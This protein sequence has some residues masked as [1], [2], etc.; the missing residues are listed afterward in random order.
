MPD[1]PQAPQKPS[2][3]KKV[4]TLEAIGFVWDVLIAIAI[5]TVLFALGGRW[6][7]QHWHT[8]PLFAVIGLF[9][10]LA[11]TLVLMM[12]KAKKLSELFKAKKD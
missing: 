8:S 9:L 10:A 4:S 5:P 3:D 12:R 6:M 11:V 1:L 7:D 2:P